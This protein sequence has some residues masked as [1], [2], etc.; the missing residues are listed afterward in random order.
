MAFCKNCG[1]ELQDGVKFCAACGTP[2]EAQPEQTA[3]P[4]QEPVQQAAPVQETAQPQQAKAQPVQYGSH[5]EDVKAN[6]SIAWL[7]YFGILLLIPMLA[8]KTS[9]YCEYHVRQGVTLFAASLAYSI[10]TWIINL[11]VA[12]IFP[13]VTHYAYFFT[14]TSPSTASVVVS[15]I[16]GIASIF[17]A[18]LAII[19]IVNAAKGEEKPLPVLGGIKIFDPLMDK[20]YK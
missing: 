5:E 8:R 15:I 1:K 17:F 19:G 2:V 10:V 11:I 16:L 9:K 12:A 7:S 18:V 14:Y 3:A 4:A 13:P 6:K 20:F